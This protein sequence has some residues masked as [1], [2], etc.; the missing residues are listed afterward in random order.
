LRARSRRPEAASGFSL[1][2]LMVVV[3]IL[4]MTGTA[5]YVSWQALL[6][7]QRLNTAVR[8]LSEV[9]YGTRAEAIAQ[10]REYQIHYDLDAERYRVRTPFALEGGFAITDDEERLWIEETALEPDGL[11]IDQIM[12]DDE[13]YTDGQVFV[14][15][16]PLG[17]SAYH[18]I[19]LGQPLFDRV[20]TI[21]V[22]P[23]TGDIRFHDGYFER[24]PAE[25]R[26]FD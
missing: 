14:S 2:E 12:I 17:K 9:L 13:I 11:T 23:L 15:F 6:P 18:T 24:E 8:K 3:A 7:N 16:D 19:V 5:V 26:D 20:F 25:D 21:E 4:G 22:L 10:N 1:V